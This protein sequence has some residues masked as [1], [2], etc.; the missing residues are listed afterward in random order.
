[1]AATASEARSPLLEKRLVELALAMP[2]AVKLQD[3]CPKAG[4]LEAVR[5]IVPAELVIGRK[6][7]Y[8]HS[9]RRQLPN[10]AELM[11]R[12]ITE[13]NRSARLFPYEPLE[14]L[15]AEADADVLWPLYA[16]SEWHGATLMG[17][18]P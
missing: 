16:F 9:L 4:F 17:K 3:Q 7:G 13:W 5:R 1:M 12:S 8:N 6:V 10:L 15:V 11:G 14:R 2:E 18:R